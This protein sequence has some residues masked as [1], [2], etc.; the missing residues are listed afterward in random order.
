MASN[1]SKDSQPI[2][3]VLG[4][5]SNERERRD[6]TPPILPAVADEVRTGTTPSLPI[7]Q[8]SVPGSFNLSAQPDLLVSERQTDTTSILEPP[9]L[10]TPE[11]LLIDRGS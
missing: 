9:V 11:S 3:G 6:S 1:P 7:S 5:P 8:E 2:P 4:N 10:P